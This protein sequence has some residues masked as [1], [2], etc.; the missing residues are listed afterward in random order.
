M[1]VVGYNT[2]SCICCVFLHDTSQSHLS[3][4][5][6]GIRF[7]EDDQLEASQTRLASSSG[8]LCRGA[9]DLF[10]AGK[11]FDLFTDDIDTT[12]IRSIKFKHHLSHVF[13]T[14]Y[15][16]GKSEDCTCFP[17]PWRTVE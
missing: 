17:C 6:H 13:G 3:G 5:R 10:R 15:L 14:V 11:S 12:V 2:E 7:V 8:R 1:C 4:R 16:S 9:E